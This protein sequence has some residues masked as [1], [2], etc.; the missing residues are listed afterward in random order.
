M[1]SG[2]FPQAG[3]AAAWRSPAVPDRSALASAP[4][5]W[6]TPLGAPGPQGPVILV[7]PSREG[8]PSRPP[9]AGPRS[10]LPACGPCSCRSPLHPSSFSFIAIP[11]H[12]RHSLHPSPLLS[13]TSFPFTHTS[14]SSTS[15]CPFYLYPLAPIS[16]SLFP[17][18][19]IL[20][21]RFTPGPI[22]P[23]SLR[24]YPRQPIA[25]LCSITPAPRFFVTLIACPPFPL[26]PSLPLFLELPDSAAFSVSRPSLFPT[27]PRES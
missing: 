2:S 7:P 18:R 19:P 23:P 8:S 6:P 12:L 21:S 14:P 10:P 5:R 9:A 16:P 22:P 26:S 24:L 17:P 11:L 3:V 20:H 15:R 1:E 4:G 27:L 25:L 13:P